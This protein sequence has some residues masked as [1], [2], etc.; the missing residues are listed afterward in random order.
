MQVRTKMKLRKNRKNIALLILI[1]LIAT[2]LYINSKVN[3]RIYANET[4][5]TEQFK[6]ENLRSAIL[7]LTQEITGDSKKKRIY[8]SDIDKIVEQPGGTSLKLAG[9]GIKD[10]SGLE[11]FSQKGITWIFLDWNELTDISV[12]ANFK[13]LTKISFSGNQVSDLTPLGSI[14][15]LTN[16]TA[17][18]NKIS[19]I[20]PLSSLQNIQYI[21][22]DGNIIKDISIVQNWPELKEMSFQNNLIE[23]IPNLSNQA[24]LEE[25]N[26]GNNKIQTINTIGNLPQLEKFEIGNNLLTS[27]DG[28]QNL[29]NLKYVSCSN[30]QISKTNEL[31][32]LTNLE[33]LN[34]NKNQIDDISNL[35]KNQSLAYIYMDGNEIQDFES[36]R[37]LENLKK[38]TIYN[39][40]FFKEIK[41][42]I[43]EDEVNIEL[44]EL[45]SSLYN[46]ESFIYKDDLVVEVSGSEE[47][48][49][50]DAKDY[51]KIKKED[52]I[53]NEIAIHVSDN[54]NTLLN[55]YISYDKT[56]PKIE[57]IENEQTYY[58]AVI[59]ACEDDDV[60]QVILTKDGQ[61]I[62]YNLNQAIGDKGVY[63]LTISD[64]AGNETQMGFTIKTK[65]TQ[66]QTTEY[67]I[68]E[69]HIIGINNNTKLTDFKTILGGDAEYEVYNNESKLSNDDIIGTGN[70]LVTNYDKTF[71]LVVKADADGNGKVTVTDLATANQVL[72]N[73]INLSN[74]QFSALD[75]N[76]DGK[77][78]ATDL[79]AINQVILKEL[80]LQM[81]NYHKK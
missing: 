3:S 72:L 77:V 6:D 21:N 36:L 68:D 25:I 70:K 41:E 39:Q 20:D 71:Y 32:S 49:I 55:Y 62:S 56:A 50:T 8:E 57:G 19:T 15:T 10:L 34:I 74:E 28:L 65:I 33:N 79:A 26:L 45:Y 60:N 40:N 16:I 46:N 5:I 23:Q 80:D 76:C 2:T 11:L 61:A 38:Y 67:K 44:P 81:V 43:V 14:Q 31:Q 12:I 13:D 78:T 18:N 53:N 7:E 75:L 30:N 22:L 29:T 54:T 66:T 73:E 37:N 4:D 64:K 9:L 42:K 58:E 59:P 24:N 17:I 52:L 47:Y 63:I 69:E 51:I 1:T 48:E 35:Q 27:L